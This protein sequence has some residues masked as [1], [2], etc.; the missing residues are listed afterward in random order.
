MN[1]VYDMS[2]LIPTQDHEI[3]AEFQNMEG[4]CREVLKR[5]ESKEYGR[6]DAET[7]IVRD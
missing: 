7:G 1:I 2:P 3:Y 5:L 4:F 6:K